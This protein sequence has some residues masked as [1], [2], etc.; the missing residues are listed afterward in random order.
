MSRSVA[1]AAGSDLFFSGYKTL[2]KGWTATKLDL[3]LSDTEEM[4]GPQFL[5]SK[6][7]CNLPGRQIPAPQFLIQ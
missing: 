4:R 2:Q 1:V 7:S 5:G 6:G 3:V